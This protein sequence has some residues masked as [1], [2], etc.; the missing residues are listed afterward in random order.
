[1]AQE[2]NVLYVGGF[3]LPDRNA[4]ALRVIANGKLFNR[5][6]YEVTYIGV[7]KS[8]NFIESSIK[9]FK[10]DGFVFFTKAQK[11]PDTNL[12]WFKFITDIS[13]VKETIEKDLNNKVDI[14]VAYNYP[15]IT[16][17]KLSNYSKKNNIKIIA[18]VSE[19][20]EPQGNIIF[21]II[22]GLDSN[23]RMN[24]FQ[25]QLD[26]IIAISQYLYDYYK[27]NNVIKLPPLIDKKSSKWEKTINANGHGG[28]RLVYVGSPGNGQKDR[29][30]LI[31]RT[32]SGIKSQISE[33][34]FIIVGITKNQYLEFFG[35]ESFP[36]NLKN[37]LIFLGRKPHLDSINEIKKSDFSIFLRD[38]N[39][40]NTAGFPTKFVES[41][42]SGTPVLTNVSSNVTD[43]LEEGIL[44]YII[45]TS[46]D[47]S[48]RSSLTKSLNLGLD[49]IKKMKE[50]CSKFERFNYTYYLN[51][52]KNFL[53]RL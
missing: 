34:E 44:G 50:S 41:V 24:V 28:I 32:L 8:D 11:Y 22:K 7:D 49:N 43:Y 13:F 23:L 35:Q 10:I 4:A 39:L 51:D 36:D 45:N 53:S 17:K 42:S 48:L 5:L 15:A 37:N 9:K 38:N 27:H 52:F 1:M 30:D 21:R 26:G 3:E 33:F 14:I 40:V 47:K 18:D 6:G 46:T 19:W 29:L 12:N 2:K 25:K 31:I 16:L 20:Y